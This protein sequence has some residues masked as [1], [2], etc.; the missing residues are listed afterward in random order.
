MKRLFIISLLVFLFISI[1]LPLSGCAMEESAWQKAEEQSTVE[2]YKEYLEKYPDGK[3]AFLFSMAPVAHGQ[4][5][6]DAT[7][8]NPNEPGPHRLLILDASGEYHNLNRELPTDWRPSSVSEVELVFVVVRDEYVK[9]N[10]EYYWDGYKAV[11][12]TI[13]RKRHEMDIEIREAKTGLLLG[14]KEFIGSDPGPFPSSLS[15]WDDILGD[16]VS[17]SDL[18]ECVVSLTFDPVVESPIEDKIAFTSNR[19]GNDEIYIMNTDG[20][21][22]VNLTNEPAEDWDPCFSPDRSKIAF[23]SDRDGNLEIYIMHI[24]GKGLVNL[25][26]NPDAVDIFPCFTPDGSK[27]AFTSNR[28]GNDEIYIMNVDG[29]EQ[30]NLTNN[31]AGDLASSFSP[32]GSK[33]AFAS[34]RD[35]MYFDVYIMNTDSSGLVNL[36]NKMVTDI[37]PSFS[38][39]GSKIVFTSYRDGNDEIYIMNIDGSEQ[40]NLTNNPDAYDGNPC[41]SP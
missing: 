11:T 13:N 30:V 24:G 39:D 12:I 15:T 17:D 23:A 25:T 8:Y 16:P 37:E 22:L 7:T 21:G 40:V 10:S 31:D 1:T 41:F 32:D 29:S 6:P 26:D 34:K 35:G 5:I 4:G 28:D 14:T 2:S 33:I 38:P 19:D 20:S 9:L 18:I 27:I 36:T 3:Y